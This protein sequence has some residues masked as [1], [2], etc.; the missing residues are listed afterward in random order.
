MTKRLASSLEII[1]HLFGYAQA[2]NT[3]ALALVGDAD[4]NAY[5]LLFSFASSEGK[6]QFLHLVRTNDD[7]GN[8]YIE[9]DFMSP[10]AEEI[11]NARPFGPDYS[12][13]EIVTVQP[14]H[15][16]LVRRIQ[17]S[18]HAADVRRIDVQ[19]RR[20]AVRKSTRQNPAPAI[21]VN[22]TAAIGILALAASDGIGGVL[23]VRPFVKDK[24]GKCN[25]A[26]IAG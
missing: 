1:G 12:E 17:H 7:M 14:R 13:A 5:E 3:R 11:R 23:V 25:A 24:I 6:E 20:A 8:D 2:T 10:T 16:L 4:A 19:A 26:P 18:C 22:V 15:G 21:M 9:N